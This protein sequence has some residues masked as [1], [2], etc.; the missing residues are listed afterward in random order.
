VVEHLHLAPLERHQ[1]GVRSRLADCVQRFG[2]LNLLDALGEQ[3]SH[4]LV[5][6]FIGHGISTPSVSIEVL[7]F[8]LPEAIAAKL[9]WSPLFLGLESGP[10]TTGADLLAR[11]LLRRFEPLVGDPLLHDLSGR[12]GILLVVR[13]FATDILGLGAQVIALAVGRFLR[14]WIHERASPWSIA[15]VPGARTI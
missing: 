5:L 9:G 10:T 3:E 4:A 2:Q 13:Q 11:G 8:E 12:L 7:S 14:C 1:L 6:K 15:P